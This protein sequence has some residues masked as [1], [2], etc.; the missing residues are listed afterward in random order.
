MSRTS[1]L[2][3]YKKS[4]QN[5]ELYRLRARPWRKRIKKYPL[6]TLWCGLVDR[7]WELLIY[8]LRLHS[9]LIGARTFWGEK[10][11]VNF[12]AY[13]SVYHHGLIDGYELPV[14]DFFV[15]ELIDDDT[16][17]DI[18]ANIGFYTL[19]ASALT[20]Y[21][22]S[23]EPTPRTFNI[24]TKNAGSKNNVTLVNKAC[25]DKSGP[26]TI[27]DF[28]VENSGSN[29]TK[30]VDGA[31]SVAI[32]ATTVD[33]YCEEHHASPSVVKIDVE[34]AESVVITG[35][36]R[37]LTV[38]KPLLVIELWNKAGNEENF[39]ATVEQLEALGY[40]SYQFGQNNRLISYRMGDRL[41]CP[42]MVFAH[43]LGRKPAGM[44]LQ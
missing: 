5:S 26:L 8:A 20:K 15:R 24:L 38:H 16:F 10:I 7:C 43:P 12:P 35:A 33:S 34:G 9:P 40:A 14:E 25:M 28:G 23:F 29:T 4:A 36:T 42:N 19:L 11:T 31:V 30:S 21:V 6:T 37:T 13:R 17:F 1:V 44:V 27:S 18:G 22:H 39:K 32:Y 2:S 3:A 41:L